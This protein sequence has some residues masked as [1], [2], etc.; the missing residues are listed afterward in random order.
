MK[1]YKDRIIDTMEH[2]QSI[3]FPGAD[4]KEDKTYFDQLE[5]EF[6]QVPKDEEMKALLGELKK[7]IDEKRTSSLNCNKTTEE[8]YAGWDD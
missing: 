6:S 2:L 4:W 7:L 3:R 5:K 1:N 8:L